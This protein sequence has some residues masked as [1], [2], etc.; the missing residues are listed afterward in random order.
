MSNEIT[1]DKVRHLRYSANSVADIEEVLG[2]GFGTLLSTKSTVG[3]RHARALLWGGL[4]HEDRRLQTDRGLELTGGLIDK[5]YA[6]GKTLDMLYLQIFKALRNDGW[7]KPA[8]KED[9][10]EM[11]SKMGE[12][13]G[14]ANKEPKPQDLTCQES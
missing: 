13:V 14:S 9:I 12:V 2:A 5:W 8:T 6:D 11:E 10:D 7:L 1:I 3:V 4:K